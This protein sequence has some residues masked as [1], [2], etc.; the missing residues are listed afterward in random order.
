ME[1][2]LTIGGRRFVVAVEEIV[3]DRARVRVDGAPYEVRL[4]EQSASLSPPAAAPAAAAAPVRSAASLLSPSQAAFAAGDR[5]LTAPIPGRILEVRVS[6]GE[7]VTAGQTVAVMEAMKMENNLTA[8][9]D[10]VVREIRA[11]PGSE[12]ATGD[13]IMLFD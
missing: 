6:L 2:S 1:Y 7:R 4:E 3:G 11:R 10:G 12:V 13:L 8:P 9:V 5:A